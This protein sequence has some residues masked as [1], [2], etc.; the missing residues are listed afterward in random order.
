MSRVGEVTKMTLSGKDEKFK[1]DKKSSQKIVI[2][3]N[4]R[5]GKKKDISRD[6]TQTVTDVGEHLTES[7]MVSIL[8]G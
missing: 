3:D 2:S 5:D 8:Y 7:V 4:K 1:L 6:Q